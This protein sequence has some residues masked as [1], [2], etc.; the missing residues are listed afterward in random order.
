MPLRH[1]RIRISNSKEI[2]KIE[3]LFEMKGKLNCKKKC[4]GMKKLGRKSNKSC[5]S[6]LTIKRKQPERDRSESS[7]STLQESFMKGTDMCS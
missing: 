2:S 1:S 6:K 4:Q 3:K 7:N 5:W